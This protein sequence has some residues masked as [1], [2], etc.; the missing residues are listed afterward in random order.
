MLLQRGT[1]TQALGGPPPV[2]GLTVKSA[3][4]RAL[5]FHGGPR[6]LS[7]LCP[8]G[9]LR[10][11]DS[12]EMPS[13]ILKGLLRNLPACSFFT[14]SSLLPIYTPLPF[15]LY[16]S[17]KTL[18]IPSFNFCFSHSHRPALLPGPSSFL[19]PFYVLSS[20]LWSNSVD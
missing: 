9:C 19:T 3:H 18:C 16:L 1:Q 15:C 7:P 20:F 17:F 5:S 14:L 2:S 13:Y 11:L 12:V 8:L 10:L 6:R 4:T